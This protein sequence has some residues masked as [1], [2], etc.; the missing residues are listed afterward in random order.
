MSA[1]DRFGA[2][3]GSAHFRERDGRRMQSRSPAVVWTAPPHAPQFRLSLFS[4]KPSRAAY[5]FFVRRENDSQEVTMSDLRGDFPQGKTDPGN[6]AKIVSAVILV[7]AIGAAGAYA[8]KTGIL[9]M[10]VKQAVASN[11]LP[12]PTP[13]GVVPPR[14]Q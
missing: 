13:P 7:A 12:S 14:L 9:H 10:P 2:G 4:W 5:V 3:K 11:E 1:R 8:Y 6:T